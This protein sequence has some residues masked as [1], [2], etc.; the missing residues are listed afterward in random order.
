MQSF[1]TGD[2]A[3]NSGTGGCL[4]VIPGSAYTGTTDGTL[5]RSST[6]SHGFGTSS[7]PSIEE[8]YNTNG[9][10]GTGGK[11][12]VLPE[13]FST[14]GSL[15]NAAVSGMSLATAPG[16][17]VGQMWE[18]SGTILFTGA[19]TCTAGTF[20]ATVTWTDGRGSNSY[21]PVSVAYGSLSSAAAS[22]TTLGGQYNFS[23]QFIQRSS[24]APTFSTTLPTCTALPYD[25][26]VSARR[27]G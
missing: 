2:I 4:R 10:S 13:Y 17:T 22:G 24:A 11:L 7:T 20:A 5:N 25:W 19:I 1:G 12:G 21:S 18:V 16:S 9:G 14:G 23:F 15:T 26:F 6:P 8:V 3:C 27:I